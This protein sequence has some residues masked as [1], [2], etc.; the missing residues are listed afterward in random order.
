MTQIIFP[1]TGFVRAKTIWTLLG[2]SKASFYRWTDMGILDAPLKCSRTVAFWRAEYIKD[3]LENPD[4]YNLPILPRPDRLQ[5]SDVNRVCFPETGFIRVKDIL[6]FIPVCRQTWWHLVSEGCLPEPLHW[7]K[8]FCVWHA[9]DI[10]NVIADPL[11]YM[12]VA[13]IAYRCNPSRPK[14]RRK[15]VDKQKKELLEKYFE[16]DCL[17]F[18]VP[19]MRWGSFV[20]SVE[21]RVDIQDVIIRLVDHKTNLESLFKVSTSSRIRDGEKID[22]HYLGA[23]KDELVNDLNKNRT[24]S[25]SISGK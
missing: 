8:K 10:R 18:L 14:S 16:P 9:S 25:D 12:R 22:I 3:I 23:I 4:K 2:I 1:N 24:E 13:D 5:E 15:S 6:Q 21:P 11:H 17:D 19:P 20:L 7:G